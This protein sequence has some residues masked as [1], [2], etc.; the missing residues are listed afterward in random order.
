MRLGIPLVVA[1]E[2]STRVT[3][4]SGQVFNGNFLNIDTGIGG[5][6]ATLAVSVDRSQVLIIGVIA[7]RIMISSDYGNAEIAVSAVV[8]ENPLLEVSTASLNFGSQEVIKELLIG[9]R[10]NGV[11][12]WSI[13]EQ[14]GWIT[15]EPQTGTAEQG[16]D[17][18]VYAIVDRSV[19]QAW[20]TYTDT[21][22]IASN[23]GESAIT[24]SMEK[25]NHPPDVPAVVSPADGMDN[26]PFVTALSCRGGDRD[27][28]DGDGVTYDIFLSGDKMLVELGDV[29]ALLCSN[30]AVCYCDSRTHALRENTTYYW[31]VLAKDSFNEITPSSVWS[32]NTQAGSRGPCPAAA[33]E[34]SYED[35]Q[36]LRRLRDEVLARDVFAKSYISSYYRHSWELSLILLLHGEL[37]T[38]AL[39]LYEELRPV[40]RSLVE[41]GE[42]RLSSEQLEKIR[43]LLESFS[44]YAP[45]PLRVVLAN[46][47][48]DLLNGNKMESLGMTIRGK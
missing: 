43:F 37:R 23:G 3:W 13:T 2:F 47:Q 27:E 41:N 39:N 21:V 45:P 30:I 34:L 17:D 28:G 46:L 44:W 18:A 33:L 12:S 6:S 29:S 10:G 7:G 32:F 42:A 1:L 24:V 9:N 48:A 40:A 35:A 19:E 8:A 36:L 15:V 20:G 38:Q 25:R 26:Q 11:L 16:T 31:K 22:T 4:S 5:M 14:A